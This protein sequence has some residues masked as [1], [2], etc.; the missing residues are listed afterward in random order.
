MSRLVTILS[1]DVRAERL[2][3]PVGRIPLSL[4]RKAENST[5]ELLVVTLYKELSPSLFRYLRSIGLSD[6][7][8]EDAVQEAFLR[9]VVHLAEDGDT[10]NL[11]AWLFRVAHNFSVNLLRSDRKYIDDSV[12]AVELLQVKED[13]SPNPEEQVLEGEELRRLEEAIAKL[14]AQQR[15]SILLRAQGLRYREIAEVLGVTAQTVC[16]LI[17]RAILK[18]AGGEE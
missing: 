10:S 12:S 7:Q 8:A 17:Q 2:E 16:G 4:T 13:P 9:L 11:R 14:S 15:R 6:S 18:L 1:N 3:L 5:K